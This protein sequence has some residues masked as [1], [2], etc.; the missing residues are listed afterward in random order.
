[1]AE[2]ATAMNQ[3]ATAS[4]SMRVQAD[5]TARAVKDQARTM[6]EMT[7]ASQNTSRQIKAISRANKEQSSVAGSLLTALA[8]IRRI[9]ERNA[10]GIKKTR[11]GT[12]DLVRRADALAALVAPPARRRANGR[13]HR[14]NGS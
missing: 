9:T 3:I 5:Q 1:M 10:S 13:G 11:G 6:V 8:E 2:Q 14:S 4:E 12:D 7:T